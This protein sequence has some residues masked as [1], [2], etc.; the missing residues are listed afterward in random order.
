M[1]IDHKDLALLKAKGITNQ[2]LDKQVENFKKGF[3]FLQLQKPAKIG[4]GI[5][6]LTTKEIEIYKKLYDDFSADVLK[7]VP[8]SG[9]A[10]RMFSFLFEFLEKGDDHYSDMSQITQSEVKKFF[11]NI[12][13]FAFYDELEKVLKDKNLSLDELLEECH[14]KLI[15]RHFLMKEGLNYGDLPKGVILFHKSENEVRTSVEE[16]L[17]EGAMYAKSNQNIVNIHFTISPEHVHLF[18]DLIKN[19]KSR[20]ENLFSV[21]YNISFSQQKASTDMVAVDLENKIFRNSD[22]SMLFRPGGHGALIENLN[23][24][25]EDIIFI[26]NIDNVA[27]DRLKPDTIDYKKSLAGLLLKYRMRIFNY[28]LQIDEGN[29]NDTDLKEMIHFIKNE[30]CYL[31]GDYLEELSTEHLINYIKQILNRPIRVCGMV[32]NEGEPGG[33]PFWVK[34]KSGHIDL[35]I[36]ESSQIDSKDKN[37]QQILKT[38]THFNPVDLVI[39]T[40]DYKGKKFNLLKFRDSETGFISQKTKDGKVLKAQEL[41]GLWNGAMAN[42]NTILLKYQYPLL[43]L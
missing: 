40:T 12:K 29:Y 7:F 26:K 34:H 32:K 22:G 18:N 21:K 6:K 36:V 19:V 15:I 38:S 13:S 16:H 23:D 10:S 5:V 11:E 9:A 25:K 14:F 1:H 37:Q 33:G 2:E 24:L 3:P 17:A 35:Q 31:P 42:W 20:Y 27:P 28:L 41:P 43:I 8:A 4:D 30:L 39:S